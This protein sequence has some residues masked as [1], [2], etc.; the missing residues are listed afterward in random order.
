MSYTAQPEQFTV[1]ATLAT[2]NTISTTITC[3]TTWYPYEGC[4]VGGN[5]WTKESGQAAQGTLRAMPVQGD[6]V[7]CQANGGGCGNMEAELVAGVNGFAITDTDTGTI[8]DP[9]TGTSD[10]TSGVRIIQEM[11]QTIQG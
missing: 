11:T 6:T 5:V 9:S 1:T 7:T 10:T 8:T 4:C 2:G 3:T